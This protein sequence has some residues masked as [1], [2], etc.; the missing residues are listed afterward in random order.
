MYAGSLQRFPFFP[1]PSFTILIYQQQLESEWVSSLLEDPVIIIV[2][3][4]LNPAFKK[5]E[6]ESE[7]VIKAIQQGYKIGFVNV[8]TIYMN[9]NN[10][11]MNIMD[12]FRFI[13]MYIR[14]LNDR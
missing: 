5:F 4:A 1:R 10:S 6:F 11:S 8:S 14:I 13:W 12:V 9:Q 7:I 3:P 2:S